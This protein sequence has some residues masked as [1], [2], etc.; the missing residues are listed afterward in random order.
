MK[1][2]LFTLALLVAGLFSATAQT[3]KG[4]WTVGA[5]VGNFTYSTQN[6]YNSFSGSL[7]PSAGYFVANNLAVGAGIPLS[8]TT[9]KFSDP[10]GDTHTRTTS[11]GLS[12]Y[13]RYYIGSSRLKPYVGV[14]YAYSLTNQR[15]ESGG[16]TLKINGHISTLSP[17]VGVAY[18]VNRTVALNAGL[19]YI[20][21]RYKS[22]YTVYDASGNPINEAP[23]STTKYV[24]L[25]IGFQIFFG[26]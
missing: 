21:Q 5:S 22:G 7:T 9:N 18:F 26:K 20:W 4:R 15:N 12:P 10:N 16:Q 24:S 23:V 3:E 19:S 11:V 8:L 2:L 14:S 13:V 6:G 1:T 17:A 25:G